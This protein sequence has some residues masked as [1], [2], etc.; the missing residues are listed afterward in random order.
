V[1]T[2][3]HNFSFNQRWRVKYDLTWLEVFKNDLT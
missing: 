3:I 1:R 2:S